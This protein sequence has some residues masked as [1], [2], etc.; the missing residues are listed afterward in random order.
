MELERVVPKVLFPTRVA[1]THSLA[2]EPS[3][4]AVR[5][6]MRDQAFAT[7]EALE[8]AIRE[9]LMGGVKPV[10]TEPKARARECLARALRPGIEPMLARWL[11]G[12]ALALDPENADAIRIAGDRLPR[13][14]ARLQEIEKAIAA[15][16][17]VAGGDDAVRGAGGAEGGSGKGWLDVTMRPYLRA[18]GRRAE[19]WI[20]A[21]RIPEAVAE[22]E[23]LLDLDES[24]ALG[25]R[26][27]LVGLCVIARKPGAFRRLVKRLPDD[28]SA[29]AIWAEVLFA[30][31]ADDDVAAEGALTRARRRC[32]GVEAHVA[33]PWLSPDLPAGYSHEE[34]SEGVAV[35]HD[36]YP[37]CCSVPGAVGWLRGHVPKAKPHSP[38]ARRALASLRPRGD[39]GPEPAWLEWLLLAKGRVPEALATAARLEGERGLP[40]ILALVEAERL[41]VKGAVGAGWG[42]TSAAVLLEALAPPSA[43]PRMANLLALAP[44]DSARADRLAVALGHCGPEALEPLLAAYA[45]LPPGEGGDE[46]RDVFVEVMAGLGVRDERVFQAAHE[47]FVRLPDLGAMYFATVGDQRALPL[48]TA[49]VDEHPIDIDD[50]SRFSNMDLIEVL[51]TIRD[52]AGALSPPHAAIEERILGLRAAIAMTARE[53]PDRRSKSHPSP[54]AD[55]VAHGLD[56]PEPFDVL[57]RPHAYADPDPEDPG[58][59][60]LDVAP[61]MAYPPLTPHPLLTHRVRAS[62]DLGRNDPC[63]C[64]STKKYKR[65]CWDKDHTLPPPVQ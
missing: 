15:G 40:W 54:P 46:V 29:W 21:G 30:L 22:C 47:V 55:D 33:F 39:L 43:L 51:D 27:R 38:R 16:A 1:H 20:E 11:Q 45:S 31:A 52:L 8:R 61:A 53:A 4:F 48:L 13:L 37:A 50:E 65:C 14:A 59:D 64:G 32:P 34:H 28:D 36:L 25:L 49:W 35:A 19:L 17:R 12:E 9:R 63:P 3:H 42:P 10:P 44:P 62:K 5:E 23:A 60:S 2:M 58:N 26:H 18:R 56:G 6:L 57:D 41:D 7:K 24:D